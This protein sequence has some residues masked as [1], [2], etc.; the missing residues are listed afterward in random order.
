MAKGRGRYG[1]PHKAVR[2]RLKPVVAAGRAVCARCGLPIHPLEEWDLGHTDDG[3]RWS[4]PEHRRCNRRDGAVKAA[5][6]LLAQEDGPAAAPGAGEAASRARWS[7]HWFG[8]F[9]ERCPVCRATGT[10]CTDGER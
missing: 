6:A 8:G 10:L 1:G 2:A 7:R 3:R 5:R 9:D 4:G